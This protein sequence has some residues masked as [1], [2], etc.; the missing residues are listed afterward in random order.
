MDKPSPPSDDISR[1]PIGEMTRDELLKEATRRQAEHD[2]EETEIGR[3]GIEDLID[4]GLDKQ[5]G[6]DFLKEVV[7]R[8]EMSGL[9]EGEILVQVMMLAVRERERKILCSLLFLWSFISAEAYNASWKNVM[10]GYVISSG[11]STQ[12]ST[13]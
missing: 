13:S 4:D 6:D 9:E 11:S 5:V 2:R 8:K 12:F 7:M 10:M 1:K 3:L